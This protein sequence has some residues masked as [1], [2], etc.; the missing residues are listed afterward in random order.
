MSRDNAALSIDI[1]VLRIVI[2]FRFIAR[3]TMHPYLPPQAIN[4]V[5]LSSSCVPASIDTLS[6]SAGLS[7]FSD[8]NDA[9]FFGIACANPSQGPR[10]PTYRSLIQGERG[11]GKELVAHAIHELSARAA[12]PLVSMSC[13][14]FTEGLI[15]TQLF[16]YEEGAF[17]GAHRRTKGKVELAHGGTLFLDEVGELSLAAQAKL[18]RVL[19]TREVDRASAVSSRLFPTFA[20]SPPVIRT[21]KD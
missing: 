15:D 13:A 3:L 5:A 18:L 9:K 8:N 14:N 4:K 10:R 7:V 19:E 17:T 6:V 12:G 21:W 16:G 20:W 2:M 1:A 11:T